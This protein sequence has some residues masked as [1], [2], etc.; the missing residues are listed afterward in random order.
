MSCV[1]GGAASSAVEGFS[2]SVSGFLSTCEKT[3]EASRCMFTEYL[4]IYF[5]FRF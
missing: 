4:I 2:H 1:V 3:L 5:F